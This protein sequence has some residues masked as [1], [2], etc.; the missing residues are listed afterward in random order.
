MYIMQRRIWKKNC[1]LPS[2][3]SVKEDVTIGE[4]SSTPPSF[5]MM[6]LTRLTVFLFLPSL[7]IPWIVATECPKFSGGEMCL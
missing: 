6:S 1:K 7:R 3:T 2:G 5:L 4:F